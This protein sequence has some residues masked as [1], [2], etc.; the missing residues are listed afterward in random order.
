MGG[1]DADL[2]TPLMLTPLTL[3]PNTPLTL[4]PNT[5][6]MLTPAIPPWQLLHNLIAGH[7]VKLKEQ[8]R[9]KLGVLAGLLLGRFEVLSMTG[10]EDD[11][12]RM[13][14]LCPAIYNLAL[15]VPCINTPWFSTP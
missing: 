3:P 4:P 6:L 8:N 9:A 7:N 11:T 5:P 1:I 10:R 12:P 14:L 13:H 15:Q 2:N